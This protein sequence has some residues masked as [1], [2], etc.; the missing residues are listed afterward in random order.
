MHWKLQFRENLAYRVSDD[1]LTATTLMRYHF[2]RWI[3]TS[4]SFC[5]PE[6]SGVDL[7]LLGSDELNISERKCGWGVSGHLSVVEFNPKQKPQWKKNAT[8]RCYKRMDKKA[9]FIVG[10]LGYTSEIDVTSFS[11]SGIFYSR[12]PDCE[13]SVIL[14]CY[15]GAV[16]LKHTEK[17]HLFT[18]CPRNYPG[19]KETNEYTVEVDLVAGTLESF[20]GNGT[21]SQP[22]TLPRVTPQGKRIFWYHAC[23]LFFPDSTVSLENNPVSEATYMPIQSMN[24]ARFRTTKS[25]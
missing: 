6:G 21:L 22:M 20:V 13:Y 4:D 2:Y 24:D 19:E 17:F 25:G 15:D 9:G 7:S 16:F 14:H 5:L 8:T 3:L 12:P 23:A 10:I 18:P 11:F 1:G